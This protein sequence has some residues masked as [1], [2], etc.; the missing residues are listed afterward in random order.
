MRDFSVIVISY[1]GKN[2]L[3][4]CLEALSKSDAKPVKTII[5]DDFSNDG[6][7]EM[8]KEKFSWAEFYRNEKNLGPTASRNRGA[9]YAIGEYLIF[10]DN[11]TLMEESTFS[12]LISFLEYHRD[13]GIVGAKIAPVGKEKMW[14]N[15]GYDPNFLKETVGYIIGILIALRPKSRKLKDLSMKYILNYW[16]YDRTLEVD[17]VVESCFAIRREIF[18]KINGFDERFFMFFEGPDLCKRVRLLRHKVYFYPEA[19]AVLL[20]GHTHSKIKR[21]NN[22]QK[23]RF[24]YYKKHYSQLRSNPIVF[25]AGRLLS[26]LF[27]LIANFI[28]KIL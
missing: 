10:L 5:V 4:R 3:E 20:E 22:F 27:Y 14:W 28:D 25:T 21:I 13:V 18:E 19:K 12:K 26:G 1:N 6:M 11:D 8:I 16:D 7:E 2:F 24:L 17:W 15:M 23:S 9:S